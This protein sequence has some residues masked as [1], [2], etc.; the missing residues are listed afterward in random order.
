MC[1]AMCQTVEL[2]KRTLETLDAAVQTVGLSIEARTDIGISFA[3][4]PEVG[5]SF[6]NETEEES[7]DVGD[8]DGDRIISSKQNSDFLN[9]SEKVNL[10]IR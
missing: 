3:A 5:I 4:G 1:D 7:M 2:M 6:E 10:K 9:F 8:A